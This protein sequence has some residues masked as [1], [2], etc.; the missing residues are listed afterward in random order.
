MSKNIS[1]LKTKIIDFINNCPNLN[2]VDLSLLI[3][4]KENDFYMI[5]TAIAAGADIYLELEGNNLLDMVINHLVDDDI[6]KLFMNAL[7]EDAIRKNDHNDILFAIENGA[8]I[9]IL[10][11]PDFA[12]DNAKLIGNCDYTIE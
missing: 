12:S 6:A 11:A 3:G 10:E 2:C 7:L 4:L 8:N 9:E 5:D 1:I